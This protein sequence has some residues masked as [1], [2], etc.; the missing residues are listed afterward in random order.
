VD[1]GANPLLQ[2]REGVSALFMCCDVGHANGGIII[3]LLYKYGARDDLLRL[4]NGAV[5]SIIH[6]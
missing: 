2:D 3:K 4:P 6:V 1:H 5:Y